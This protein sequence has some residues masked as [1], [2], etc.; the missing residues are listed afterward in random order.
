MTSMNRSFLGDVSPPSS[1]DSPS[2]STAFC[3]VDDMLADT[4]T[5]GFDSFLKEVCS[6][7]VADVV[8]HLDM[9]FPI[10]DLLP[11][12]TGEHFD[13][14]FPIVDLPEL[15][16]MELLNGTYD[17]DKE[18]SEVRLSFSGFEPNVANQCCKCNKSSNHFQ[19]KPTHNSLF[20]KQ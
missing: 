3:P 14:T 7:H 17:L 11:E 5:P 10:V 12:P 15:S 1:M 13:Q 9:T 6:E 8:E 20:P 4:S 2:L 18:A 19:S 16:D